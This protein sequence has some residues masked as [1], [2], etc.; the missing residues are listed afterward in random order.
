MPGLPG[1]KF[2]V[3]YICQAKPGPKFD[4]RGQGRVP[5]FSSFATT[6]THET[7][8]RTNRRICHSRLTGCKTYTYN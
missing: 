7:L 3:G 4:S 5:K 1:P 6:K 8:S 2:F